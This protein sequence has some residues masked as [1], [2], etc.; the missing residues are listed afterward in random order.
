M[1]PWQKRLAYSFVSV[2]LGGGIVGIAASSLDALRP[3]GAHL[4]VMRVLAPTCVVIIASLCGWL[5]AIPVILL[6]RDYSAWRLWAWGAVGI[7]IGP[8]VG[9]ALY[10]ILSGPVSNG[11]VAAASGFMLLSLAVS[12]LSTCAYLSLVSS[13]KPT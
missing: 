5:V 2:L 1:L 4:D 12:T 8:A 9:L 7:C 13:Q 11:F 3:P 6:V 10:R